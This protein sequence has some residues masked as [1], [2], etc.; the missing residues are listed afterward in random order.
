MKKFKPPSGYGSRWILKQ[1]LSQK[2]YKMYRKLKEIA[3]HLVYGDASFG[4]L[5]RLWIKMRKK[6]KNG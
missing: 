3:D 1:I 6:I 5:K 4:E 2:R